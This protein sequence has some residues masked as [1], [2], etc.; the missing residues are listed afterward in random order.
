MGLP[1][2]K[3]HGKHAG[4]RLS[5]PLLECFA[6]REVKPHQCFTEGLILLV[7]VHWHIRPALPLCS[8]HHLGVFPCR[9]TASCSTCGRGWTSCPC[10][11][12]MLPCWQ[13]RCDAGQWVHA[14]ARLKSQTFEPLALHFVQL[15][16]CLSA[17]STS[18]QLPPLRVT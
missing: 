5:Q 13:S 18:H 10:S 1:S 6:P 15:R 16:S 14:L 11:P 8:L 7:Q 17:S 12:Q 4:K 2:W 9:W 3:L